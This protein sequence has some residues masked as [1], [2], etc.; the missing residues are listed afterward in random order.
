[1]YNK[2]K[3][4]MEDFHPKTY[5][6]FFPEDKNLRGLQY[7]EGRNVDPI[8]FDSSKTCGPGGIY[9]FK[10]KHFWKY[11]YFGKIIGVIRIPK[12]VPI[13]DLGDKL[14]SPEIYIEKFY[15][16]E[17]FLN[18]HCSDSIIDEAVA[19]DKDEALRELVKVAKSR[20]LWLKIVRIRYDL[21]SI[22]PHRII[23]RSF[24]FDMISHDALFLEY[25]PY[26]MQ[27]AD[28][29]DVAVTK[30]GLSLK[31]VIAPLRTKELYDK[32][33]AQNIG[34]FDYVPDKFKTQEMCSLALSRY[35]ALKYIPDNFKTEQMCMNAVIRDGWSLEYVPEEMKTYEICVRAMIKTRYVIN[36]VPEKFKTFDFYLEVF[37]R[38][39]ETFDHWIFP[40]EPAFCLAAVTYRGKA[41]KYV[42]R[43]L[44]TPEVC[45]AAVT[46]N[47]L[48]L[49]YVETNKKTTAI[50]EAAISQNHE[51]FKFVHKNI[52]NEA[53][54]IGVVE[55]DGMYLEFVPKR[56]K[57]LQ[58]CLAAL[59][60]NGNAV[61]F[62]PKEFLDH[63]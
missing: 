38:K 58:V 30:N 37:T 53:M 18:I 36:H 51:A 32:A 31:H 23:D 25:V 40:E 56:L 62:F 1:M 63:K 35:D 42:D 10:F 39:S 21:I 60:Q 5:Y 26:Y 43:D 22:V 45:L 59:K 55:Q 19:E 46:Q 33:L 28:M 4:T 9:Y 6:K 54:C 24:Y 12:R 61:K 8:K 48:A 2:K 16:F 50:C 17:E 44:K 27:D 52:K 14:K 47:G 20:E 11:V 3:S 41:L 57:S 15:T 34:A 29:A 13:V 7:V 49:Q